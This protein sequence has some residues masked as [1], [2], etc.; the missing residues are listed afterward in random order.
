[1]T[2]RS[3]QLLTDTED[4]GALSAQDSV[5]NQSITCIVRGGGSERIVPS[6]DGQGMSE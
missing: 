1:M 4:V 3:I 6:V 2:L 5:D